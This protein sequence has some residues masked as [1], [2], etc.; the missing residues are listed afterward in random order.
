LT[1]L[2][3]LLRPVIEER[4]AALGQR[5]ALREQLRA[6]DAEVAT[7]EKVLR[8]AGLGENGHKKK[9]QKPPP[10]EAMQKRVLDY[11]NAHGETDTKTTAEALGISPKYANTILTYLRDREAIRLLRVD[12]ASP[13]GKGRKPVYAPWPTA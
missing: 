4:D 11:V 2:N 10:A 12:A 9:E 5:D 1:E 8:A 7:L 13:S 6:I 3:E